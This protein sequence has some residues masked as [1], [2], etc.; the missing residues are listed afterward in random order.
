MDAVGIRL[1]FWMGGA[2]LVLAG[3][4]GLTLFRGH[5]FRNDD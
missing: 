1:V 4:L 2:L 3:L 5:A